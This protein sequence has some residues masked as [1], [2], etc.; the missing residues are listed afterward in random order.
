MAYTVRCLR[1]DADVQ[2][3]EEPKPPAGEL[4]RIARQAGVPV[5]QINVQ[6]VGCVCNDC[7]QLEEALE[8]ALQANANVCMCPACRIRAAARN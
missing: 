3:A 5:D 6:W 8:R 1:C 4:E 2:L 7:R